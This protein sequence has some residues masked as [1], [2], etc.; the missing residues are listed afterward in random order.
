L[1][2]S[3]STTPA[4]LTLGHAFDGV[5][6][7]LA[8]GSDY[9]CAPAVF[10]DSEI[11]L[12][13]HIGNLIAEESADALVQFA[14]E[15][16]HRLRI[17][18]EYV[19]HGLN[20]ENLGTRIAQALGTPTLPI[21]HHHAHAVSC[22]VD[23]EIK[24]ETLALVLDG[25]DWGDD[26]TLWGG[27]LM[28]VSHADYLRLAHI[29][30]IELPG[31]MEAAKEPWRAAHIWLKKCFPDADAPRLPWH[32]RRNPGAVTSLEGMLERSINTPRVSSCGR[33]LDAAASLLDAA[34]RISYE[35]EAVHALDTLAGRDDGPLAEFAPNRGRDEAGI[36]DAK[37]VIPVTDILRQLIE[38]QAD[39]QSPSA[40]ARRFQERLAARLAG[41]VIHAAEEQNLTQVVLTGA[42]FESRHLLETL[43]AHLNAA[44]L[45]PLIH[46]RIPPNDGGLAVGQA[47]I[48][49]ARAIPDGFPN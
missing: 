39:G 10:A 12:S 37:D 42:C 26:H 2:L 18:P 4:V 32:Q 43:Y 45:T 24:G 19:T 27:E 36:N 48:A 15:M 38:E 25:A 33:L 17:F 49:A 35:G 20:P 23:N 41:A 6:P 3:R 1:R 14:T 11:H 5:P 9:R 31:G 44:S 21:Q 7:I 29:E 8:M 16:C 28:R 47:A 46:R 13:A 40:I 34:D 22:L 30:E